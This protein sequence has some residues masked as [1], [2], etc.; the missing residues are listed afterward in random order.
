MKKIIIGAGIAVAA[1][2]IPL[3]TAGT[4][5]AETTCTTTP[6]S[7]AC[8]S[9]NGSFSGSFSPNG[10]FALNGTVDGSTRPD[11][12]TAD[13]TRTGSKL[14]GSA[15]I[16]GASGQAVG[17]EFNG[18]SETGAWDATFRGRTTVTTVT[19]TIGDGQLP[20]VTRTPAVV[21]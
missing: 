11:I 18:D 21:E 13:L 14:S 5:S 16:H 7:V 19:D 10:D 6:S 20:E 17:V 15:L 3:L 1:G 9:D 12:V 8:T 4:A 2:V